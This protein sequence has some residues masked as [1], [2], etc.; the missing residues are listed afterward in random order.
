LANAKEQLTELV[1]S[2][3]VLYLT[4][5]ILR[6]RMILPEDK[7]HVDDLTLQ[8]INVMQNHLTI[9]QGKLFQNNEN[10]L[11]Y[12][13]TIKIKKV[14]LLVKDLNKI[15]SEYIVRAAKNALAGN[16]PTNGLDEDS[17][18]LLQKAGNSGHSWIQIH[19]GRISLDIPG[20]DKIFSQVKQ[21][22]LGEK[23][24]ETMQA[25]LSSLKKADPTGKMP[26]SIPIREMLE[27]IRQMKVSFS[28]LKE[29]PWSL[30]Q[31]KDRLILSLGYGENQ[32]MLLRF[33]G[34]ESKGPRGRVEE[35]LRH[36]H[37]LKV[38]FMEETSSQSLLSEFQKKWSPTPK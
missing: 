32:P 16:N 29:L 35:L 22:L 38:D 31:R 28:K 10:Q 9:E 21:E 25:Y 15:V 23:H 30:D 36:A 27:K 26:S 14:D 2:G 17:W 18:R 1:S 7:T 33:L 13:Q 20:D 11:S 6:L 24:L 12:Y 34:S 19:P 8:L 5:P 3:K 37:T 4:S